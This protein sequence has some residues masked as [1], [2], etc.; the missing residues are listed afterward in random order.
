MRRRFGN[1]HGHI[2]R[3]KLWEKLST[4][5]ARC[6]KRFLLICDHCDRSE[7]VMTL[8]N[9][10]TCSSTFGTNR[11]TVRRVLYV[12]SCWNW[13]IGQT[14]RRS[15]FEVTVWTEIGNKIEREQQ[16]F[17]KKISEIFFFFEKWSHTC[18]RK[19]WLLWQHL[20]ALVLQH[21]L[22]WILIKN[23]IIKFAITLKCCI[24]NLLNSS[25][26]FSCDPFTAELIFLYSRYNNNNNI[27]AY[28]LRRLRDLKNKIPLLVQVW[29]S[30]GEL[31]TGIG[32][33]I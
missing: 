16:K 13:A 31:R 29:L 5:T 26:L 18:K 2:F 14:D 23:Y 19:S 10:L 27:F 25:M 33:F 22:K 30:C 6:C 4:D 1:V 32:H 28:Q 3:G 20:S 17:S 7:V 11:W 9:G 8:A 24:P 12:A 21:L 15:Y